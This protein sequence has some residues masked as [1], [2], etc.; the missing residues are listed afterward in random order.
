MALPCQVEDLTDS[1][2]FR[3]RATG[4]MRRNTLA[5]VNNVTEPG[6]LGLVANVSAERHPAA[7]TFLG[8]SVT[9]I[10][11]ARSAHA[12]SIGYANKPRKTVELMT[13]GADTVISTPA[14]LTE[15]TM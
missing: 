12:M 5:I 7:A 10:H 4:I 9:D 11:A 1:P 13:A 6:E 8:D 14:T 3:A 2:E 15:Q